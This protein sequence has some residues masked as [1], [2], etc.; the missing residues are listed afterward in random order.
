MEKSKNSGIHEQQC[1]APSV[2]VEFTLRYG[3]TTVGDERDRLLAD[4][5]F[6]ATNPGEPAH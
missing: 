6:P 4:G 1:T 5:L 2:S 3:G